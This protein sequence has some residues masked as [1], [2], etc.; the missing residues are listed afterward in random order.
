MTLD[1]IP[2]GSRVLV[3]AN[4][5]IYM[6]GRKSPQCHSLLARCESG[7]VQGWITSNIVAEV[8]HRRM[9]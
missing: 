3:D 7:A 2:D 5:I 6:L 9:M 1:D 4:I 8:C